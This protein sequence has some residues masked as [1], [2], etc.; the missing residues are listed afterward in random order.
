MLKF[1]N[2]LMKFT[3]GTYVFVCDYIAIVKI[4]QSNLYMMYGDSNTNLQVANF[5]KFIDVV[6]NTSC[7][8]THDWVTNIN[9]G[10]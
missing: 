4:C 5:P 1:I 6:G 9:D 3:Q 10:T 7:R 2:A 8:V